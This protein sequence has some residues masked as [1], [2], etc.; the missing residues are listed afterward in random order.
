MLHLSRSA[1]LM[2][3]S[4]LDPA[5]PA[6]C[7]LRA[8]VTKYYSPG[9]R[10]EVQGWRRALE[11]DSGELSVQTSRPYTVRNK[12]QWTSQPRYPHTKIVK[13]AAKPLHKQSK[14][15]LPKEALKVSVG[16]L[17]IEPGTLSESAKLYLPP[18]RH[19]DNSASHHDHPA[20]SERT[21]IVV[22][23]K[24][25]F[26]TKAQKQK[27]SK[28]RGR[29]K[30]VTKPI[31]DRVVRFP[32]QTRDSFLL[33]D[34]EECPVEE[35][36][37]L[38]ALVKPVA[39][40]EKRVRQ[41]RTKRVD[42]T[43]LSRVLD[44]PQT[45]EETTS[46]PQVT[47]ER[48]EQSEQSEESLFTYTDD[49]GELEE[50]DQF[51]SELEQPTPFPDLQPT[52]IQ[53]F[54]LLPHEQEAEIVSFQEVQLTPI[55]DNLH[56]LDGK[57]ASF[58]DPLPPLFDSTNDE[59][60]RGMKWASVSTMENSLGQALY[61]EDRPTEG[62][63]ERINTMGTEVSL[64]SFEVPSSEIASNIQILESINVEEEKEEVFTEKAVSQVIPRK[65]TDKR[66]SLQHSVPDSSPRLKKAV[67]VELP[68][69]PSQSSR[70]SSSAVL[71][72]SQ[73]A[74]L[75]FRMQKGIKK[76]PPPPPLED[77]E[78][79][80]PP[81]ARKPPKEANFKRSNLGN[82]ILKKSKTSV[83]FTVKADVFD[84][85]QDVSKPVEAQAPAIVH[86]NSTKEEEI[87]AVIQEQAGEESEE[88]GAN[89]SQLS[90][91]Y[92]EQLKTGISL[93]VSEWMHRR[94]SVN[95]EGLQRRD[96]S[97]VEGSLEDEPLNKSTSIAEEEKLG[98]KPRKETQ[99]GKKSTVK[100]AQVSRKSTQK[101]TLPYVSSIELPTTKISKT[102]PEA[103]PMKLIKPIAVEVSAPA[104][105]LKRSAQSSLSSSV[106]SSDSE[107]IDEEKS[108]PET[109]K[110][111]R[112]YVEPKQR[113]KQVIRTKS[114]EKSEEVKN[115]RRRGSIVASDYS[116]ATSEQDHFIPRQPA[117]EV[118]VRHF[119]LNILGFM[120]SIASK[121]SSVV[122]RGLA[123][124][125]K[126][127]K[128]VLSLKYGPL[129]SEAK[130]RASI[131][132]RRR[133]STMNTK[134]PGKLRRSITSVALEGL[135]ENLDHELNPSDD[136]VAS[137]DS[138]NSADL[139]L[140]KFSRADFEIKHL[141]MLKSLAMKLL[142]LNQLPEPEELK[143]QPKLTPRELWEREYNDH[144]QTVSST[145]DSLFKDF[146]PAPITAF[147]S[148]VTNFFRD[149]QSLRTAVEDNEE[150][151]KVEMDTKNYKEELERRKFKE[152]SK[153]WG[154]CEGLHL[155]QPEV[156]MHQVTNERFNP[157]ELSS[158]FHRMIVKRKLRRTTLELRQGELPA[159]LRAKPKTSE[160][161]LPLEYYHRKVREARKA[162]LPADVVL[163]GGAHLV[164]SEEEYSER[165]YCRLKHEKNLQKFSHPPKH[166]T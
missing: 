125:S 21:L 83:K 30:T 61:P 33:A 12:G 43:G 134:N 117:D 89:T 157:A 63:H 2:P 17:D 140:A 71:S 44:N 80:P 156:L 55:E 11:S 161:G 45:E 110:T 91:P 64:E 14:A 76:P 3:R 132:S 67:S 47:I 86:S 82:S 122:A 142:N 155:A 18:L 22:A 109:S 159:V 19:L 24:D 73:L 123:Q 115:S 121:K 65:R 111:K 107:E 23:E 116:D 48:T 58:Q 108:G 165:V 59:T 146:K 53:E 74:E 36:L 163:S 93:Q 102:S 144:R 153:Q 13:T 37:I 54:D 96:S 130:H 137:N 129:G 85:K 160:T 16:E 126:V 112:S 166:G 38:T 1:V 114:K 92:I 75:D 6:T 101:K 7:R 97:Q 113:R 149:P 5:Q 78:S 119:A 70:D 127:R 39:G 66:G 29:T 162:E 20:P 164:Q 100:T 8:L 41:N 87:Y 139:R 150:L 136:E 148:V 94:S 88:E 9:E 46:L 141:S 68:Y 143:I 35:K 10:E 52:P 51:A 103:S 98:Y 26:P 31:E 151:E 90:K 81:Q 72:A 120:H 158:Y 42:N 32:M 84:F 28:A 69:I 95:L 133:T 15:K 106:K 49:A 34:E 152:Y 104:V 60:V 128:E 135:K 4:M 79:R 77:A 118:F 56:T 27:K 147:T 50:T 99:K 57:C 145:L 105:A 124:L 138:A 154:M 25:V 62:T 40:P 131:L